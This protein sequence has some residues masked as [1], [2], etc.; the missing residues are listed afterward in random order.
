MNIL[1]SLS[2]ITYWTQFIMICYTTNAC[3]FKIP[4]QVESDPNKTLIISMLQD[5][6]F[7]D[8]QCD[9]FNLFIENIMYKVD[10][11]FISNLNITKY[12]Q[13]LIK[14][15]MKFENYKNV[16]HAEAPCRLSIFEVLIASAYY[17]NIS[18]TIVLE[19]ILNDIRI[20]KN[21]KKLIEY[22]NALLYHKIKQTDYVNVISVFKKNINDSTTFDILIDFIPAALG[23]NVLEPYFSEAVKISRINPRNYYS[24]IVNLISYKSQL[25]NLTY[26]SILSEE[27]EYIKNDK[28][29]NKGSKL[30]LL[31]LLDKTI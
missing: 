12:K 1:K 18:D 3:K 21:T 10:T 17:Y 25:N 4:E 28:N 23:K 26:I 19:K 15:E 24:F 29:M 31:D 30:R 20:K 8:N 27:K 6:F 11:Q 9:S 5:T 7:M 14:D 13:S 22:E 2:K 16:T